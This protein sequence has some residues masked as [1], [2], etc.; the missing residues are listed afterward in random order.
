M[1]PIDYSA[2]LELQDVNRKKKIPSKVSVPRDLLAELK[3]S[4]KNDD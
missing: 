4:I 2:H 1:D 3:E